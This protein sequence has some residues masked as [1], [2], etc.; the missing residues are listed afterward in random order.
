ME[1]HQVNSRVGKEAYRQ[2]SCGT[3]DQHVELWMASMNGFNRVGMFLCLPDTSSSTRRKDHDAWIRLRMMMDGMVLAGGSNWF[4]I[5]DGE[6]YYSN[7]HGYK[8]Q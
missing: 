6:V 1:N 2:Q 5:L 3:S 7:N 4:G 8:T